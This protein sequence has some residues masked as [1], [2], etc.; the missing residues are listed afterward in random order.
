MFGLLV[1]FYRVCSERLGGQSRAP[2]DVLGRNHGPE[3]NDHNLRSHVAGQAR[4]RTLTGALL[5][6]MST[7][8]P[9]GLAHIRQIALSFLTTLPPS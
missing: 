8:T 7:P 6:F 9:N 5:F 4:V 1:P 3:P 2:I